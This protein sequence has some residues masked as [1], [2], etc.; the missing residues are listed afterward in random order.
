MDYYQD[1]YGPAIYDRFMNDGR[2]TAQLLLK[3]VTSYL[4]PGMKVLDVGCG[5][6]FVT[7]EVGSLV[8]K[9]QVVGVDMDEK[10]LVLARHKAQKSAL[11]ITFQK[12]D[13]L[14]LDFDDQAFDMALANQIPVDQEKCLGEM[15][16]VVQP[17][18]I[19][20]AARPH[21]PNTGW[22]KFLHDVACKIASQQG[23]TPPEIYI[24]RLSDPVLLR[25]IFKQ[26]G[27]EIIELEEK[28][29]V[30]H[31]FEQLLLAHMVQWGLRGATSYALQI[32]QQD[33][34]AMIKGCMDFLEIAESVWH[35][36]YDGKLEH[37]C[38]IAI[39]RKIS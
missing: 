37:G 18:S 39:G 36:E 33:E 27:L 31:S 3:S 17:G 16:R 19:V 34:P 6:G 22:F 7:C 10:A 32:D 13:A 5:T 24:H 2:Q 11:S 30:E 38:I 4:K 21:A 9:G 29:Y 14:N 35:E 20:G 8:E 23:K 26:V 15:V 25:D 12:G 1:I 28:R